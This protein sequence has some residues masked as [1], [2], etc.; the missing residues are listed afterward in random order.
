MTQ[1]ELIAALP[2]GRLPP[3]LTALH[4][5]D[6]LALFGLGLIASAFLSLLLMPFAARRPSKRSLI[7]A[8]RPLPPEERLLA[9]ARILGYL[10]DS[11][12]PAAYGVSPLPSGGEIERAALKE[13]GFIPMLR[14]GRTVKPVTRSAGTARP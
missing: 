2:Q 3:E 12:R 4:A 5:A 7:R 14:A 9:V 1:A 6:L 10:P 8:T 13:T 11:L